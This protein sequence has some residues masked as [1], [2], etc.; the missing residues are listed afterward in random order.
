M[1]GS[2]VEVHGGGM[3]TVT[4]IVS[5]LGEWRECFGEEKHVG[6]RGRVPLRKYDR[7]TRRLACSKRGMIFT[8]L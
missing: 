6:A 8:H 4:W 1:V 3:K 7:R 2:E 5:Y